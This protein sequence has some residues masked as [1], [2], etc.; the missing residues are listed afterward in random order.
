MTETTTPETQASQK[1]AAPSTS[2]PSSTTKSPAAPSKQHSAAPMIKQMDSSQAHFVLQGKGGVG[3]SVVSSLL[4]QFFIEHNYPV[5][6]IDTD[7]INQSFASLPFLDT[8]AETVT[9]TQSNE[10]N[11]RIIDGIMGEILET[12]AVYVVDNGASSFI[13]MSVYLID[14]GGLETLA[15]EGVIPVIHLVIPVGPETDM[16]VEGC[17]SLIESVGGQIPVVL[18][19]NEREDSWEHYFGAKFE[20]NALYKDIEES[21]SGI[22]TIPHLKAP[23]S[24][25]FAEML[26][27]KM[28]FAEVSTSDKWLFMEKARMKRIKGEIFSN[29]ETALQGIV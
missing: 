16:A 5:K 13:P 29:I 2:N 11:H 17:M 10:T 19:I 21:V 12:P 7:P 14:G 18:W 27:Q 22:V 25:N 26:R 23:A 1:K 24:L 4:A 20:D 8:K 9:D 6:G 15:Q 3:K 28:S